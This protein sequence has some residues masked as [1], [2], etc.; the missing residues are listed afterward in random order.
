MKQRKLDGLD[1]NV[2]Q[3][4]QNK[5]N[6]STRKSNVLSRR[7]HTFKHFK[8]RLKKTYGTLAECEKV[9]T[10]MMMSDQEDEINEDGKEARARRVPRYRTQSCTEFFDELDE[11]RNENNKARNSKFVPTLLGSRTLKSS[12]AVPQE[13]LLSLP[14]WAVDHEQL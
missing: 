3:S 12:H 5:D 4:K 8:L 11:I 1:P 9:L 7:R 2:R 14:D 10:S 6:S 13:T